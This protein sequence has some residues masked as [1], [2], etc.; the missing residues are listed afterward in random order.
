LSKCAVEGV[1][2]PRPVH[3]DYQDAVVPLDQADRLGSGH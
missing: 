3:R 1:A 2:L